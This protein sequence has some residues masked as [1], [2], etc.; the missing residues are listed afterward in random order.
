MNQD[1][2]CKMGR[3]VFKVRNSL[4]LLVLSFSKRAHLRCSIANFSATVKTKKQ[5]CIAGSLKTMV[6]CC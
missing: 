3:R 1:K 2:L 5:I 4:F 6:E